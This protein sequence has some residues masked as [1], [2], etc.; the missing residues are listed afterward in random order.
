[1]K[2]FDG[3]S[4]LTSWK[5][6]H[7]LCNEITWNVEHCSSSKK[8]SLLQKIVAIVTYLVSDLSHMKIEYVNITR[9]LVNL[10]QRTCLIQRSSKIALASVGHI[11]HIGSGC[12]DIIFSGHCF[13]AFVYFVQTF[14]APTTLSCQFFIVKAPIASADLPTAEVKYPWGTLKCYCCQ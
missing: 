2:S 8:T 5:I 9:F 3:Y 13:S 14:N 4:I 10:I 6:I 12:F 11:T 1:M 7:I